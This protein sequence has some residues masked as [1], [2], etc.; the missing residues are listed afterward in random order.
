MKDKTRGCM[1]INQKISKLSFLI[2]DDN[3]M[4]VTIIKTLLHGFGVHEI[5]DAN[6]AVTVLR[7][8]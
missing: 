2:V 7:C 6:D 1:F 8:L 3:T 5:Y 4:M